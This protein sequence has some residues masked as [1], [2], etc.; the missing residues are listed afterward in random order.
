MPLSPIH[1]ESFSPR[2]SRSEAK[3][4]AWKLMGIKASTRKG[5]KKMAEFY[6]RVTDSHKTVHF[7][8]DG[9]E[10]FT[11]HKDP[12]RAKLYR[13]RHEKDLL[14]EDA[15]TGMTPGALSYYVL[16]TSPSIAQGILN[17]KNRYHL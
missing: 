12:E 1:D 5:K 11:M 13:A 4:S 2:A 16:W 17:Y 8:A 15:K 10:D 6:D 9:Y 7:G 3:G 14:T